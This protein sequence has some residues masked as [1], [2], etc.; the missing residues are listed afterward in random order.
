MSNL[1][2]LEFRL[3]DRAGWR[4]S[5]NC[6]SWLAAVSPAGRSANFIPVSRGYRSA[7]QGQI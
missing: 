4:P 2:R 3:A 1:L 6:G 7:H 5:V